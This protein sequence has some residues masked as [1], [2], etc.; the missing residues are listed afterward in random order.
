MSLTYNTL[1]KKSLS[2]YLILFLGLILSACGGGGDDSSPPPPVTVLNNILI[3]SAQ[4]SM[5]A[6][7]TQQLS[8]AGIYSDGT[9]QTIPNPTWSSSNT[10]VASVDSAGLV[11]SLSPGSVKISASFN[12][13]KS[14]TDLTVTGA[15]LQS[16]HVESTTSSIAAGLTQQFSATGIYSDGS[17]QAITNP[18]WNSSNPNIATVNSTGLVK[19]LT[20]GSVNI[21]AT[22]NGFTGSSPLT[23]TSAI[24]KSI[25]VIPTAPSVA[26][27]LT[28]QF[29][30]AGIYSDGTS[31][32]IAS[33]TWSSSNPS[34][35]TVNTAGLVKSLTA[36]SVNITAS[37]GGVTGSSTLTVTAATLKAITVTPTASSIA[38]GLTQQLTATGTYSDGTSQIISNPVWSSS[39]PS[40]A[41]VSS[42]GLVKTLNPGTINLTASFNGVSGSTTLKVTNA[43]VQSLSIV[44]LTSSMAVGLT[45]Q[46]T[47]TAHYS[48]GTLQVIPTPSLTNPTMTWSSS[49]NTVATLSNATLARD[50]FVALAPG[51]T[52]IT[53]TYNGFTSSTTLTVTTAAL[54]SITIQ[55]AA[56]SGTVGTQQF[57]ATGTYTDGT[58]QAIPNPIWSSSN[59]ANLTVSSTGL[60]QSITAGQTNISATFNGVIGNTTVITPSFR[61]Y[62]IAGPIVVQNYQ[63]QRIG[64]ILTSSNQEDNILINGLDPERP[65]QVYW[66][67][68]DQTILEVGTALHSNTGSTFIHKDG[69]VTLTAKYKNVFSEEIT[70]TTNV[71]IVN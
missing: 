59:T 17:T 53:A 12:G 67:T 20:A 55:P 41:T 16:I 36:G 31:Q 34:I 48:D 54:T 44:P 47:A 63:T 24:L 14:S 19:S 69:Q 9:S 37:F 7:L 62:W 39:G 58:T 68:S 38:A 64:Y 15:I 28:Q 26:A 30:A 65:A 60:A 42:T 32:P 33:P 4:P 46:F 13:L 2:Y 70:V 49:N 50:I 35:A 22:F 51:V 27:G 71:K 3:T 10:S 6:G 5:A 56:S 43:I 23:I 25:T 1:I 11:K 21:T 29:S 52:T 18:I 66:Y 40:V 45:Q 61:S 8:V 57:T